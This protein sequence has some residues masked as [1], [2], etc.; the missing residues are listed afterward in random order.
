MQPQRHQVRI[1][2][3]IPSPL[4]E[5]R[6]NLNLQV[7]LAGGGR[8]E[9]IG[10]MPGHQEPVS[11]LK[12]PGRL[13]GASTQARGS[14]LLL[15]TKTSSLT[16]CPQDSGAPGNRHPSKWRSFGSDRS[17]FL[18][19]PSERGLLYLYRTQGL[20]AV[21]PRGTVFKIGNLPVFPKQQCLALWRRRSQDRHRDG[22]ENLL[23]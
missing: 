4:L 14:V 9:T 1:S 3:W 20:T 16:S 23:L 12:A 7:F 10:D 21:F 11:T 5:A 18:R 8:E 19:S 6:Q 22:S 2:T 13:P 17:K 15:R